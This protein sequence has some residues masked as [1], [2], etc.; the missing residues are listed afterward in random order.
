[1]AM[2]SVPTERSI[3]LLPARHVAFDLFISAPQ[4][5]SSFSEIYQALHS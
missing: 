4:R 3:E 2:A 1:M 5:A